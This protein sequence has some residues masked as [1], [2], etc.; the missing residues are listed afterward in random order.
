M[1]TRYMN[2]NRFY[3]SLEAFE[4]TDPHLST[5]S[6]RRYQYHFNWWER[7]SSHTPGI[8]ILTGGRQVGKSTSCKQM[9]LHYLQE[10]I[11]SPERIFY[12]PCDEIYDPNTLSQTIR[13]FLE[14]ATSFFLLIIDE[15]TFVKHWERAIKAL[16]DEGYFQRG[17]C[18][19]TGSD[20]FILKEAAMSF[21]GRRGSADPTDF[22]LYPLSF[23]AYV[24][25]LESDADP[26]LDKLRTYFQD[27]L[28]CGGYLSAINDWAEYGII[29]PATY[30]TYEQWIRGDFI[31]QRKQEHTLSSVLLALMTVASSQVSYSKL[32]QKIGTLNK[33][34]CIDY[35][36]LLERMGV[37]LSL[38]AY[39]QNKKEGA[40]R[41]DQKFH[42]QD[43][44]IY[45][46]LLRWLKRET[47]CTLLLQ[48][49]TLVEASV[50]SHCAQRGRTYYFKGQGEIDVIWL[51]DQKT[52]A[53]EVK[54][55]NQLHTYDL[56]MLRSFPNALILTKN[57]VIGKK[58]GIDAEP[59]YKYLYNLKDI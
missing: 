36:H 24:Q 32:T 45:H 3:Q 18:L 34:T 2:H 19:L 47:G 41:K 4:T 42:F 11:V 25:L 9:I 58:E 14:Q 5:L 17:I 26:S 35:C 43:P 46:T 10:K 28:S 49:S 30:L 8:Y 52:E 37:I 39:D 23:R 6:Q 15:I 55:T 29:Q 40:P 7:L 1:L 57:P 44:F 21:P 54:W 27:Y 12:L 51:H 50:A 59:V 53:L 20:L 22:H 13:F 33:D 56:K 38:K 48:E 16:A 31:K